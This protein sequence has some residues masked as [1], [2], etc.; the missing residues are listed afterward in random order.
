MLKALLWLESYEQHMSTG[1]SL[2]AFVR[3]MG[4]ST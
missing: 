1:R 2:D 4:G 3:T